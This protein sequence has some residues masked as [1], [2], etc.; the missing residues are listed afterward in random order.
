MEVCFL[1]SGETL[2]VLNQIDFEGKSAKSVKQTL[3]SRVGVS[4]F[5]QKLF[6]RDA[7]C[8]IPDDEVFGST[9]MKVQL[10]V[11][12]FWQPDPK[13]DAPMMLACSTGD[14]VALERL[15]QHPRD[16]NVK[17]RCGLTPLHRAAWNGHVE[18]MRLLLEAGAQKDAPTTG[19]LAM[20][21]L[22]LA[23][24]SGCLDA[25][26]FLLEA[27][28]DNTPIADSGATPLLL[29]ACDG[30]LDIVRL[31]V[32][33]GADK[34]QADI[35]ATTPLWLAAQEGHGDIVRFLIDVGANKNQTALSDGSTPL[36]VAA[37][38][39]HLNIVRMLIQSGANKDSP[40]DFGSTPMHCAVLE[41]HADIVSLLID[42]KADK[43]QPTTDDGS[44]PLHIA[45]EEGNLDIV[46]LLVEAGA[47]T[48]V[49][50]SD[51]GS[52]PLHIAA[53]H[54]HLEIVRLL[55]ESGADMSGAMK[56]GKTALDLA[57]MEE[58]WGLAPDATSSEYLVALLCQGF[59]VKTARTLLKR[60][61]AG[62]TAD[63]EAFA[64]WEGG[65][66]AALRSRASLWTMLAESFLL[67]GEIQSAQK[68]LRRARLLR[69]KASKVQELGVSCEWGL[70][71]WNSSPNPEGNSSTVLFTNFKERELSRRA[72]LIAER[73]QSGGK[74]ISKPVVLKHMGRLLALPRAPG[75]EHQIG[76]EELLGELQRSFGLSELCSERPKARQRLLGRLQSVV[77]D[78]GGQWNLRA[79][80]DSELPLKVELCSGEGEWVCAQAS[81][82]AETANWVCVEHRRDRVFRTFSRSLLTNVS[83]LCFV[84]GDAA[85]LLRQLAPRSVDHIFVNFPE[86]PVRRGL[87]DAAPGDD[88]DASVDAPHLLTA[89]TF[90]AMH[91]VMQRDGTLLVHSDNVTYLRQLAVSL[92]SLGSFEN[93]NVSDGAVRDRPG[94]SG[95]SSVA[96][97][98]GRPGIAAGVVDPEASSYFDRLWSHGRFTK[99]Y[100]ILVSAVK[101]AEQTK[102]ATC[103]YEES[104]EELQCAQF[105]Q[106]GNIGQFGTGAGAKSISP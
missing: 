91:R 100:F 32:E 45:I 8:E 27:G 2:I 66:A 54:G 85:L 59:Q 4:R 90:R 70:A 19:N 40:T 43:D 71:G 95:E 72:T 49:P 33:F 22:H 63:G 53:Q 5:R 30:H 99:R 69:R 92:S 61:A 14:S 103:S 76:A 41:A 31:L 17:D 52:A 88:E 24:R 64:T 58:E 7:S 55:V 34:E 51:T 93:V 98:R 11:L 37:A 101:R 39:G 94:S 26:R 104:I 81:K 28:A 9:S 47:N 78:G 12:D 23:A 84:A 18:P 36:H 16:P 10:V 89:E 48:D 29:A 102:Q 83:N 65:R 44:T 75:P 21:P 68:S 25:V 6:L 74:P 82:D 86:P 35:S 87:G 50:T 106:R 60:I 105:K 67:C 80:F 56:N 13:Q 57:Q 97:W 20:S 73:I 15:L 77:K 46:R 79:A 38:K 3:A 96:V 42:V 62:G 1:A